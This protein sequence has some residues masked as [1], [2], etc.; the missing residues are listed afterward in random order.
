LKFSNF[1]NSGIAPMTLNSAKKNLHFL[2]CYS[3]KIS[4]R[5]AKQTVIEFCCWILNFCRA[6]HL[7]FLLVWTLFYWFAIPTFLVGHFCQKTKN[8]TEKF[9]ATYLNNFWIAVKETSKK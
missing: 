6:L 9:W 4:R 1:T 2:V 5:T 3:V 8:D 7:F